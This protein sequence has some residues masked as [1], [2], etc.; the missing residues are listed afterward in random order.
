MAHYNE[1]EIE[2]FGEAD[3]Q[4]VITI[5]KI[6]LFI[7]NTNFIYFIVRIIISY[8]YFYVKAFDNEVCTYFFNQTVSFLLKALL[9]Y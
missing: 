2:A 4:F 6:F 5:S 8:I 1:A 3:K 9:I 7:I